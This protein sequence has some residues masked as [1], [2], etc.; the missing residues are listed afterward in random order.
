MKRHVFLAGLL[1]LFTVEAAALL[2]F[3]VWDS[4]NRQDSVQV[5]EVVKSVLED[6]ENL[7]AGRPCSERDTDSQTDPAYV[8][9]DTEGTV[10]FQT[11]S[12]LSSSVNRAV[13]HRDTILDLV[14]DGQTVGKI[15]INNDS[16]RLFAKRK[17]TLLLVM[18]LAMLLQCG[19]CIGYFFYLKRVMIDP[20]EKLNGFAQ[21]IAGGNL[22]IPLSMDRHNLFGAFTE[23]FDI[24][25]SEI[26]KARIA[27]AKANV[28][29]KE[30]VAELSHDIKTP[31][32]SIKAASEVGAALTDNERIRDNYTQ[33]IYKADQINTLITNLFTATMEELEQLSVTP[34]DME[35]RVVEEML[36]SS[37]YLHR[38][39][40]PKIP[41]CILYADP[42]RLQQV[43]DNIFANS[44]KYAG[45]KIEV[46]VCRK[47]RRLDVR[48][49]DYGGGVSEEE[50]PLLREKFKRGGHVE[51]V[52]GAGLGLYISDYFM[53]EMN[54]ELVIENGEHGLAVTVRIPLS[55]A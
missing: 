14:I 12:D 17:R 45:T 11:R 23:S 24:M 52:E 9:L 29:K 27:Q 32:A 42:L 19:L 8:V 50:L 20:F 34:E 49:E 25:R 40:I 6:W 47:E 2:L 39:V 16:E 1:L 53:G 38:G 51:H 28:S 43:F 10:L 13:I 30:L 3:A 31:V 18:L 41:E 4:D 7:S 22:D 33:I 26:K 44:Y 48:I 37:D 55:M 21:R 35:S 36:E 46:M 15:I 54:G 5:N